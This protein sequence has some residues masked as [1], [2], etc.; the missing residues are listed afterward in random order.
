MTDLTRD[1]GTTRSHKLA[2][3]LM[4]V[5][6]GFVFLSVALGMEDESRIGA[7]IASS[8]IDV[9]ISVSILRDKNKWILWAKI[10]V[11]VGLAFYGGTSI[12]AGD[13]WSLGVQVILSLSLLLV[14]IGNAGPVRRAISIA[15]FGV[16]AILSISGTAF[17]IGRP[18][19]LTRQYSLV[20]LEPIVDFDVPAL[21]K[22]WKMRDP[23]S[24]SFE[25]QD[26]NLWLVN[27]RDDSHI[28]IIQEFAGPGTDHASFVAAVQANA[29]SV[30]ELTILSENTYRENGSMRT[31]MDTEVATQGT[32][33]R[34]KYSL[35]SNES[36]F[37][38]IICFAL[39][40]D[41]ESAVDDF[42]AFIEE[43]AFPSRSPR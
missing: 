42:D 1:E 8:A 39:V 24:Y 41:Y 28:L 30:G 35:L 3:V 12:I 14:L 31:L 22:S 37:I 16:L 33:L 18:A 38:Q 43:F 25:N 34:Y 6:A 23:A 21:P 40:E 9:L 32:V 11:A 7:V 5:N 27:P 17:D 10:R 26:V 15:L 36:T 29:R 2:A 13:Y 20:E 19:R 4:L